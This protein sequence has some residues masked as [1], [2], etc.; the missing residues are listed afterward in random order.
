[1]IRGYT[2]K[3][4]KGYATIEDVEEL[5]KDNGELKSIYKRIKAKMGDLNG[6]SQP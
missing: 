4:E 5:V 3:I 1:M 6:G 2:I